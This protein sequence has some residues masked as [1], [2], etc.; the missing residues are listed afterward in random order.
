MDGDDDESQES[1][2]EEEE[3]GD[4]KRVAEENSVYFMS[5]TKYPKTPGNN[6]TPTPSR[7]PASNCIFFLNLIFLFYILFIFPAKNHN[8]NLS[9][10]MDLINNRYDKF[11]V[12]NNPFLFLH[13]VNFYIFDFINIPQQHPTRHLHSS[14]PLQGPNPEPA[15]PNRALSF[16]N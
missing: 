8:Y 15:L 1:E 11:S 5:P 13:I 7:L 3:V 10:L 2:G 12:T 6:Y 4:G 9:I 14:V 16:P